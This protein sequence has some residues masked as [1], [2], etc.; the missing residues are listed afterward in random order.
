[1]FQ[2]II[3]N[4]TFRQFIDVLIVFIIFYNIYKYI[5]KTS[6]LPVLQGFMV[7]LIITALSA[8]FELNTLNYLLEQVVSLMLL[9]AIILFP[10]EIKKGLY[11][12][13][14]KE[15]FQNFT[16]IEKKYIKE[17]LGAV[18]FFRKKKW[19]ALIVIKKNDSLTHLLESGTRLSTPITQ[20]ML[21]SIFNKKSHLHDGAVLIIG[22]NIVAAACYVVSLTNEDIK[23]NLGTRH[24]AAIGLGEQSDALIIVVSEEKGNISVVSNRKFQHNVSLVRLEKMLKSQLTTKNGTTKNGKKI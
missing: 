16:T 4:F 21:M 17:I 5:A 19:G 9:A 10:S 23:G 15:I 3:E 11:R 12:L 18:A 13:G 22:N 20:E 8:I 2:T 14:G 7:I 24:R 1:M 6:V